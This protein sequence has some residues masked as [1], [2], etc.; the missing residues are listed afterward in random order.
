MPFFVPF[1]SDDEIATIANGLVDR[2][3]PKAAWTHAAHFA[4][5]LWM[6]AH[7]APEEV[8]DMLPDLIRAYNEATGTANTD[9]SG[10]HETITRASIRA[11]R[12]FLGDNA[13][14]QLFAICNALMA[15]PLGK[16][17]WLLVHW[18]RK[19]LFSAEARRAWIEPDLKALPF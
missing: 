18:S 6:L 5:V 13:G 15:S 19:R 10:Y 12:H 11:A 17:D 2:T 16:S 3:L 8:N 4:A 1:V 9:S 14:G 7:C